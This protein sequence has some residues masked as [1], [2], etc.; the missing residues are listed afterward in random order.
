M[1]CRL[2]FDI[3]W[4]S[5]AWAAAGPPV[6]RGE[7]ERALGA[8]RVALAPAHAVFGLSVRTLFDALLAELDL[9]VGSAVVMTGVNIRH[10]ADIVRAHQLRIVAVDIDPATLAPRP[11]SLAA[12]REASD[13]RLC[14]FTQIFGAANPIVDADRLR[15]EGCLVVEDAAQAFAGAGAIGESGADIRL[16][17]F[18]PIKRRTALGGGIGLFGDSAFAAR[19]AKRLVGYPGLGDSWFRRRALKYC[20]LKAA[21]ARVPYALLVRALVAAGRDPD[22]II[23][24]LARGF[25]QASLMA[26]IRRRPPPRMV[27]LL[28]RQIS[29]TPQSGERAGICRDFLAGLPWPGAAAGRHFH[30]VAPVVA[31]QPDLLIASARAAGFDA[32]RGATSLGAL[33]PEDT[34]F[35]RDMLDRIVYLP[36]PADLA[37]EERRR[38]RGILDD[39]LSRPR[40]Q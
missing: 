20:V 1:H 22:A 35:A 33:V 5:L 37:P 39:H 9:P 19:V 36:H 10:M 24:G 2:K 14:V 32:T 31:P 16:L 23:G 26:A 38:L 7:V 8:L 15:Q 30:W 12:A 34:P 4:P 21:S 40:S 3:G 13:A 28:A 27:V 25:P 11:G 6:S 17:S 29:G 18:G